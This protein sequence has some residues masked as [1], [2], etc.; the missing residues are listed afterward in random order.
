MAKSKFVLCPNGDFIWTYRFF[1]AIA[2]GAIP[3][4]EDDLPLYDGFQYYKMDQPFCEYIYD[5]D[6]V[7]V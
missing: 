1:E 5:L 4:I 2:C 3:I 6:K 7:N